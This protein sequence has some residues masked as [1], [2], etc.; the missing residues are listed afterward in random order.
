MNARNFN[1][2]CKCFF[3]WEKLSNKTWFAMGHGDSLVL[4]FNNR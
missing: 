3:L 1:K 2:F 4:T